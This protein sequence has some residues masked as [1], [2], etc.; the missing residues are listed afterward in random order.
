MYTRR[1]YVARKAKLEFTNYKN[2]TNPEVLNRQ[3]QLAEDMLDQIYEMGRHLRQVYEWEDDPVEYNKDGTQ[4]RQNPRPHRFT[5]TLQN[6]EQPNH[7]NDN[8]F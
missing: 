6:Q 2:E 4:I 8:D 3:F 7:E 1:S 5:F